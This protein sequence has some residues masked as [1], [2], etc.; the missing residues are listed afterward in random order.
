MFRRHGGGCGRAP[1]LSET[2]SSGVVTS[3]SSA[4]C[5]G[6]YQARTPIREA[7]RTHGAN[8]LPTLERPSSDE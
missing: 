5:A 3:L 8:L 7:A 4:I 2:A 1:K 6:W